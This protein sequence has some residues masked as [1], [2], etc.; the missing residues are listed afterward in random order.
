MSKT[1]TFVIGGRWWYGK[2][3]YDLWEIIPKP[4]Y[5]HLEW[6]EDDRWRDSKLPREE[7]KQ[8]E[9]IQWLKETYGGDAEMK[10]M[11]FRRDE[12]E[13]FVIFNSSIKSDTKR[14]K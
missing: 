7:M 10:V 3:E 13:V 11:E 1:R 8:K 5:P 9:I 2:P 6:T 4:R 12:K 14:S